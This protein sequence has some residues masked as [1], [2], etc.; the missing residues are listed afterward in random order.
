MPSHPIVSG[1]TAIDEG[2]RAGSYTSKAARVENVGV[3]TFAALA[4]VALLGV[5]AAPTS[6]AGSSLDFTLKSVQGPTT[7]H[8]HPP[9]GGVGD[10]YVSSLTLKNTGI[11]QLGMGA[12]DKVG[13]MQF[14]YTIRKQCLG[15]LNRKCK[16][17]ADFNTVTRLPGGTVTANGKA[18]SIAT[19]TIMIPV[20]GGTGRYKGASGSV[21]ISPA[22]SKLSTYKLSL[23]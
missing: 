22:A 13:T 21:S 10:T 3:R 17:T 5:L 8:P 2:A 19:P 7:A 18:I 4:A 20:V 16:A 14:T 9:V 23:P 1:E 12:R 6:F 15:A 11:A